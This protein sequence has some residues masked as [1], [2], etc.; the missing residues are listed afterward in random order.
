MSANSSLQSQQQSPRSRTTTTTTTLIL[1]YLCS[2]LILSPVSFVSTT[3]V[4][5]LA[6]A[7]V[8]FAEASPSLASNATTNS[9][10]LS[11]STRPIAAAPVATVA[12]AAT[13][14]DQQQQQHPP[15]T[16]AP[17][18]TMYGSE[19][20]PAVD[21]HQA[22]PG[23]QQQPQPLTSAS[24]APVQQQ[25]PQP[26]QQMSHRD[27]IYMWSSLAAGVGSGALASMLCAPLDLVRTRMQ[28]WGQV[29]R[30]ANANG[31]NIVSPK[32][33]SLRG[34]LR[35]IIQRD[36]WRG[37]FRGLGA[38]LVTVP[39]FWGV[40]CKCISACELYSVVDG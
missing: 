35:D 23:K 40:Y 32:S 1:Y 13:D 3:P 37:C 39:T 14:P 19:E 2:F 24:G 15:Q 6:V 27:P 36:G 11:N 8:S 33:L 9:N 20:Q 21:N 7:V 18:N 34:M 5:P 10:S 30:S 12:A 28:V 31:A 25:P 17:N 38:T 16:Q 22:A 29:V 4:V 26:P